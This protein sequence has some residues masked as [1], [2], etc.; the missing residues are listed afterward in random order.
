MRCGQI[1]GENVL[2]VT[3]EKAVSLLKSQT[4]VAVVVQRVITSPS[5]S[6][7]RSSYS[8]SSPRHV[9]PEKPS[10]PTTRSFI[11]TAPAGN[12]HL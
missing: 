12:P 8:G 1:N 6:P 3:H 2:G 10:T 11:N 7:D 4:D 9:T 5:T